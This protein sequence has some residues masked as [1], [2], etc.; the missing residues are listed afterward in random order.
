MEHLHKSGVSNRWHALLALT[1]TL[2]AIRGAA[3]QE[4]VPSSPEATANV[5]LEADQQ[6]KEGDIYFADGKVEIQ[7]RNLR[8]RADHV[9]YN[10]KTYKAT[11]TG[12]VLFDADTQHL[13]ADSA[14]FNVQSGEGL[15]EDVR[16]E[17]TMEHQ[18]NSNMLVS[19]NPLTFEAQEVRRFDA[20]TYWI[21]YASLTVC[22]PD[23]PSWKF[24]TSH[25][26]LHVDRTVALVN[27]NF[28]MFRIPLFYF[29]YASLPAGRRLRQSGFLIPEFA[30][31]S[32]KGLVLGEGYYWAPTDW[33]DLTAGGA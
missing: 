8:L 33:T 7:Y 22:E 21:E 14:D 31:T 3:A 18:P 15:F 4:I 29:P 28:R 11:A 32:V 17:V 25:A 12:H 27:A 26:T 1:F 20:R 5:R 13:T 9:Q 2:L 10:T 24:F 30:D 16:G 6:R 19:P 23:K